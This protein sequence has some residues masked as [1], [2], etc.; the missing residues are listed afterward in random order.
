MRFTPH[1]ALLPHVASMRRTRDAGYR[2][3]LYCAF[4]LAGLM[5]SPAHAANVS[6]AEVLFRAGREAMSRHDYDE[7]C[8]K[9]KESNQVDRAPGTVMNLANCEQKRGNVASAWEYFTQAMELLDPSDRR[10]EVAKE[11][12]ERLEASVPRLVVTL[13][14][15]APSTSL[16]LRDGT[17]IGDELGLPARVDPGEHT[18]SVEAP[19]HEPGHYQVQMLL[20][21][22]QRVE[23]RPGKAIAP[24]SVTAAPKPLP[25]PPSAES[26]DGRDDESEEAGTWRWVLAGTSVGT[27][28]AGGVLGALSYREWSTV[29]SHCNLDVD[30][31]ACDQTG[32]SAQSRGRD[33]GIA[34]FALGGV[35][36]LAGGAF[37]LVATQADSELSVTAGA[38]GDY[39]GLRVRA[40]F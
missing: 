20:G 23:V 36:L 30:P 31:H 11:R 39:N 21:D 8:L 1:P 38:L 35:G 18:I 40:A 4:A 3:L 26:A 22:V 34:A 37:I 16:V 15:D 33:F 24:V 29:Q 19:N 14:P 5:T 12:A 2:S 7:A 9:F 32:L 13:A 28:I 27:L 25:E 6:A 10:Y 17:P